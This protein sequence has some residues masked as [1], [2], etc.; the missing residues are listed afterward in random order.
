MS[1][2]TGTPAFCFAAAQHTPVL[3]QLNWGWV[4][5]SVLA[6]PEEQEHP[7]CSLSCCRSP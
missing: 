3:M 6:A 4:S 1:D 5:G 7:G 2:P